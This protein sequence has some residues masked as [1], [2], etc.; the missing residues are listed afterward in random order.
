MVGECFK[1]CWRSCCACGVLFFVAGVQ[2]DTRRKRLVES[3]R[4]GHKSNDILNITFSGN[5]GSA[6]VFWKCGGS[7]FIFRFI[8]NLGLA[9][10][11]G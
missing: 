6:E 8:F 3:S 5:G 7:P 2:K 11:L 4:V 10:R 1:T 9:S